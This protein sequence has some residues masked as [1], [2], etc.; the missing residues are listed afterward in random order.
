MEDITENSALEESVQP[1]ASPKV[2]TKR[3]SITATWERP[4]AITVLFMFLIS[5]AGFMIIG[6]VIGFFLSLPFFD[7]SMLDYADK[8]SNP[9]GHP[10]VKIP[11]FIIQ[12]SATFFGLVCVP[13]LYY[14]GVERKDP[15]ALLKP[16]LAYGVM[17]LVT[18]AIVIFF[19]ATNSVIVEWNAGLS[20]P[21]F[22]RGFETWAREMEARA[23]EITRFLTVFNSP[24]E[25]IFAVIVIAVFAGIG[26]ELVFRG[27]LQ[28][29]LHRATGNIHVAIWTSAILF[30]AIHLQFF[31]FVPRV[32]LGALFGYLYYWSGSLLIPM[33]A[34]FV[35]NGFSVLMMYLNQRGVIDIDID[36]PESAPLPVVA[37]FTVLTLGLLYYFKKFYETRNTPSV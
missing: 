2:K 27:M 25:F 32:L 11:Y 3:S 15:V 28:P 21:E 7:G 6:P 31:G 29:Q 33:F 1:V 16:K 35:N 12:G 4:A 9:V 34:H 26:E 23:T 18:A 19:I 20:F 22:M 37:I 5:M 30:S 24:G 14:F 36:T 17:L 8:L 13:A 10:D